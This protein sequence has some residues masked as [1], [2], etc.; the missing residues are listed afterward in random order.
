MHHRGL[1]VDRAGVGTLWKGALAVEK[2]PPVRQ[3]RTGEMHRMRHR[4]QRKAGPLRDTPY[5]PP[6]QEAPSIRPICVRCARGATG[7]TPGSSRRTTRNAAAGWAASKSGEG[8]HRLPVES[9]GQFHDQLHAGLQVGHV[10]QANVGVYVPSGTPMAMVGTP[11]RVVWIRP[12]SVPPGSHRPAG[13]GSSSSQHI[14]MTSSL[15][16]W[17]G[18]MLPSN[19]VIEMPSPCAPGPATD[20]CLGRPRLYP[21]PE[22]W[23]RRGS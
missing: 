10:E 8:I 1:P 3:A 21:R 17:F 16:G 12:P 15:S 22:R 20:L 9:L 23:P 4:G 6:V 2:D 7:N 13:A 18:I 5:R 19:T 11:V 14:D